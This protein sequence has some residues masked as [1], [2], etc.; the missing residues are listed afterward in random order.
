[1]YTFGGYNGTERLNDM[2]EYSGE[3]QRWTQFQPTGDV[4]S[5]RSSLAARRGRRDSCSKRPIRRW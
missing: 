3:T 5:G 1:M 2:Y 4:P